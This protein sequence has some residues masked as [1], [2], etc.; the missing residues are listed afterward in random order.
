LIRITKSAN[1]PA[2]LAKGEALVLANE[3][4]RLANPAAGGSKGR[5]FK[6]SNAVYG[7]KAVKSALQTAQHE[8]CCYCEGI[9]TAHA[10]GDVEHFRPKA[11]FQQRR[12]E[13][14]EYP[15]Y[16]WLAYAWSNLYYACELCNR[17]WKRNLFPLADPSTRQRHRNDPSREVP[18]ILDPGGTDDP[19]DH[20]RFEGPTPEGITAL[21]R[22][23][24]CALGLDR[25]GLMK[26]RLRHLKRL[27]TLRDLAD[28]PP[29]GLDAAML[30][31]RRDAARELQQMVGPNAEYS[32]MA[33]DFL[34]RTDG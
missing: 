22:S 33:Q 29:D 14:A 28:L 6:F 31:K 10:S 4:E 27:A 17:V 5:A 25:D 34:S 15:G 7:A 21:G 1:P 24:I 13:P 16:Y 18:E 30:D 11:C 9:F 32:A 8:K 23:T 19:R 20:I 3:A 26:E 12:K 2:L